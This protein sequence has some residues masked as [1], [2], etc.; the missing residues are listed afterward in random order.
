MAAFKPW[1]RAHRILE[2]LVEGDAGFIAVSRVAG[3]EEGAQER[4]RCWHTI[5]AMLRAELIGGR[6][7]RYY[8]RPEGRQLLD[9]LRDNRTVTLEEPQS[10]IRVFA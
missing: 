7:E 5:G 9:A 1:G 6:R 4:K 2:C 8:I 3:E 10:S